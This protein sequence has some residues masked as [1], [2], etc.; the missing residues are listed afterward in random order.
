MIQFDSPSNSSAIRSNTTMI[1]DDLV[2]CRCA[3][4]DAVMKFLDV[5]KAENKHKISLLVR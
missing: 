3:F 5:K 1:V 2:W 4:D